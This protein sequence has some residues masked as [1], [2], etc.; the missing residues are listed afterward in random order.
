MSPVSAFGLMTRPDIT[1]CIS[2]FYVVLWYCVYHILYVCCVRMGRM[3]YT[4]YRMCTVYCL[5]LTAVN[6]YWAV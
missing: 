1:T 6:L 3:V 5:Y 2:K 4:S